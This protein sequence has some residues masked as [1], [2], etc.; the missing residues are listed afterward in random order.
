MLF[1]S[2]GNSDKTSTSKSGKKEVSDILFWYFQNLTQLEEFR[3]EVIESRNRIDD[4][5]DAIAQ[6]KVNFQEQ[7]LIDHGFIA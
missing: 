5:I 3:T 1:F 6:A 2:Q 7:K 4:A